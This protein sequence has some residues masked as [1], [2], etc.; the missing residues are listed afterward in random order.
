[1]K[2]IP[3]LLLLWSLVSVPACAPA[4]E[5]PQATEILWDSYG[6]P[7]IYA[8]TNREMFRAFGWAQMHSHGDL[9]LRLYGESRG[10]AAQYWGEEHLEHDRWIWTNGIPGRSQ[11]WLSQLDPEFIGLLEGFV[12]GMNAYA[13][14]KPDNIGDQWEAVLPLHARDVLNHMQRTLHFTFLASPDGISSMAQ[15]W[16]QRGSNGWAVAPS[17]SASRNALLLANPHL[18]WSDFFLFYEAHLNSPT[19][20][21]YGV[22][23]VG[24]PVLGIAFN[25]TLGWTHTVN[26]I[27]ATDLYELTLRDGGYVF[28]GEV[29]AFEERKHILQVRGEDGGMREE[30]LAVKESVYGPV[31]KEIEGKALALRV[32][33]LDR[34][35]V[36][37]AWWDLGR[38]R[39]LQ[40]FQ[41]VLKRMELPLFTVIYADQEGNIMHFFGG[42]IPDR[43][44]G[45]NWWSIVP[46]DTSET[47]W[48]S[49]HTFQDM[50]I[51]VNPQSGWLQNAND[52]PWNTTSG[53]PLDPSDYPDYLAPQFMHFRAQQSYQMLDENSNLTLEEM[54]RLKHSTEMEAAAR[55]RDELVQAGQE[56]GGEAAQEAAQVLKDWDLRADNDSRGA[57]LFE[58]FFRE[59]RDSNLFRQPWSA[60][61]PLTTP[62]GLADPAAA[63]RI[64][65]KAAEK[66]KA[67]HGSLD[68]AWGEVYRLQR[69]DVDLPSNGGPGALGIFRVFG[70]Q[71]ENQDGRPEVIVGD[72]YVAAVE[73]SDPVQARAVMGYGNASQ[74]GSPHRSDQLKLLSAQQLRPVWLTR[75]EIEANLERKE[76]LP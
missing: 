35:G 43:Q 23:L 29:R 36:A 26:T 37:R 52:P 60:S 68:I 25:D 55:I 15:R 5:G 74:P 28:D 48:T 72:S 30:E 18:P 71:D 38:T 10:R 59:A 2:R 33:G 21:T 12:E 13:Q 75:E 44:E 17:R 11:L 41:N 50:P 39:S 24:L 40:E 65:E 22:T 57:V 45:Y 34:A 32:A 8:D 6:I 14:E 56:S 1:M 9:I 16:E 42:T 54:I 66:V 62:N 69:D 51:V 58:A 53:S 47:L 63:A 70:Y 61:D 46:G 73:F 76:E 64:L 27:D 4:S 31:V 49:I 20:N 67:E 7:H 3:Y 19:N